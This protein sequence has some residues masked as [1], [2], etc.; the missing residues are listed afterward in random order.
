M[1]RRSR[2][3]CPPSCKNQTR[4]RETPWCRRK[5]LDSCVTA[6]R[7]NACACAR[8][9]VATFAE[10]WLVCAVRVL[11]DP[12]CVRQY[13]SPKS[14]VRSSDCSVRPPTPRAP[15]ARGHASSFPFAVLSGSISS[16]PAARG[17]RLGGYERVEEEEST[18]GKRRSRKHIWGC[19]RSS[20]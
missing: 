18:R 7:V 13:T 9:R 14:T 4:H 20:F 6:L 17:D 5:K 11:L 3:T 15:M 8:G 16:Q 2:P 12:L 1:S 19:S 10:R